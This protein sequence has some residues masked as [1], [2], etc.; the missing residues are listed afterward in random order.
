MRNHQRHHLSQG[1]PLLHSL[2]AG[3][4]QGLRQP[5]VDLLKIRAKPSPESIT[6]AMHFTMTR[7]CRQRHRV[8]VIQ[9]QLAPRGQCDFTVQVGPHSGRGHLAD[10][11]GPIVGDAL[12][13][14][15]VLLDLG[16]QGTAARCVQIVRD[17]LCGLPHRCTRKSHPVHGRIHVRTGFIQQ[18]SVLDEQQAL[19]DHGRDVGECRKHPIR[20]TEAVK[21]FSAAIE[22]GQACLR[23]FL[24]RQ[25]HASV[26]VASQ[27][28]VE[29]YLLSQVE[30]LLLQLLCEQ[31][32]RGVAETLV[33]WSV[34]REA[35]LVA[36]ARRHSVVKLAR[37]TR[38]LPRLP[39]GC[40]QLIRQPPATRRE[41][42]QRHPA[43]P[44]A[45]SAEPWTRNS[46]LL[47]R[48][49]DVGRRRDF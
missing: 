7:C 13:R 10:F 31:R 39:L 17:D 11:L 16:G 6:D 32:Q 23:L 14:M 27:G 49:G 46:L 33:K 12:R 42:A 3:C 20:V 37:V 44:P 41:Q 36:G 40:L 25:E 21:L 24:V 48:R 5:L 26:D 8:Q 47:I 35:D 15:S 19:P 28:V 18:M 30:A 1:L 29:P 38:Q 4:L 45:Q 22:H 2:Q 34:L 9:H 43:H